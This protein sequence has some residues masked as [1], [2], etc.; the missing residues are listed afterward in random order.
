MLCPKCSTP[1]KVERTKALSNGAKRTYFK[2]DNGH[3]FNDTPILSKEQKHTPH[4]PPHTPVKKVVRLHLLTPDEQKALNPDEFDAA[5]KA[6]LAWIKEDSERANQENT[7]AMER[8]LEQMRALP[9]GKWDEIV[10]YGRLK[11]MEE[12]DESGMS[13]SRIPS[14]LPPMPE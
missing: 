10:E 11:G 1:G 5:L 14:P 4:T 8:W 2:C 13:W 3:R 9:P 12:S 6:E 7:R